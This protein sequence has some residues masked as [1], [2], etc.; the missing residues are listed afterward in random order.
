MAS[1]ALLIPDN[2][3]EQAQ[4]AAE[5]EGVPLNQMLLG[6]ITDGV[7]QQRKLRIM[8]ERAARADPGAALA[9]LDRSPDVRPDPGDEIS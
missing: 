6:L 1:V 4:A 3:M 7:D 8:R 9:I 5:E 2:V